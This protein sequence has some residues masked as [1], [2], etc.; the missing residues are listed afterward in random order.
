MALPLVPCLWLVSPLGWGQSGERGDRQGCVAMLQ[1]SHLPP[2]PHL[3]LSDASA[4]MF[5]DKLETSPL[6][7]HPSVALQTGPADGQ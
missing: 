7:A 5:S 4:V 3:A 2:S 6:P 1:T